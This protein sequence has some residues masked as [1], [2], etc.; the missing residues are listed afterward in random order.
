[1]PVTRRA[2]L[3][4][5]S[6][7]LAFPSLSFPASAADPQIPKPAGPNSPA[8]APATGEAT[9]NLALLARY[10]IGAIRCEG[11][12]VDVS[13][14]VFSAGHDGS[15]YKVDVEGRVDVVCKLPDVSAPGG[16]TLDRQGNIICCDVGN[17][18]LWR[19]SQAGRIDV[20]AQQIGGC[21]LTHPNF[22]TYDAEG[23]LFV[24]NSTRFAT[25][26]A[27]MDG[28][29][30]LSPLANGAL[31]CLRPNGVGEV[32]ASGLSWANGTAIDPKEDAIFVLQS[33]RRNCLR[34]AMNR[35]GTF[36]RPEV[37]AENFPGMPDGMAFAEDGTLFVTIPITMGPRMRPV[38][39]ILE[40]A[41]G[42]KW[43]TFLADPASSN[44]VLPTNCAFGG[45]ERRD[46]FIAN[47]QGDHFSRIR[48]HHVGH[49]LFHQR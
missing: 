8:F 11:V 19:I 40:V 20:I 36:G 37:Y 39:Q 31:L 3:A 15:I 9:S 21:K 33:T 22:P 47:V 5:A 16:V 4:G 17:H 6:A 14:N 24:T 44:L 25:P 7:A 30:F 29:E 45:P 27:I 49:R 34:I 13:G 1:M 18:A 48:T 12:V 28:G 38:N 23:N 43:T 46:L 42:G 32:I 26:K 2:F 35:N 10:G 41:P